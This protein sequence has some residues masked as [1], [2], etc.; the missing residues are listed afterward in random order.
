MKRNAIARIIIFS[1]IILVLL[2]ILLAGV[3][4]HSLFAGRTT[5]S[6]ERWETSEAD[7]PYST[8]AAESIGTA[9]SGIRD[10][11]IEWVSG[12]ITIL[13]GDVDAITYQE[14][15]VSSSDDAMVVKDSGGELVISFCKDR[16]SFPSF[17]LSV[18]ISKDLTITL[19]RDMVLGSLEIET[20]SSEVFIQDISIHEVE[21]E[22]VSGDCT[23]VNCTVKD[24]DMD[25]T[26]GNIRFSG[27]LTQLDF[28]GASADLYCVLT[29]TPASIQ[30]DSMSGDLDITLPPDSGFTV[31]LDAMSSDFSSEFS[32][33]TQNGN[34]VYGDGACR[35]TVS[36]MSGE[37]T[38]RKGQ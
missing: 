28:D 5:R 9:S 10:I 23:F 20:V 29:N 13:A 31:K 11:K 34:Y 24:L 33:T 19:P 18:D 26:S 12:T 14:S 3:S 7:I 17:G 30:V 6:S 38:I 32:A 16:I 22:G 37:V 21:F 27:A 25:T 15:P 36:A 4:F 2:V 1:I 8:S 35:I